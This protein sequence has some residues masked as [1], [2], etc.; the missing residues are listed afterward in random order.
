MKRTFSTFLACL[1]IWSGLATQVSAAM[2][3]TQD[4]LAIDARQERIEAIH[5]ELARDEV[6]QAMIELGVDPQE[7][8]LRVASMSDQ[9]LVQLEQQL[10]SLPAGGSFFGV[11][12]VVFVVLL[13]LEL[14]GVTNVFTKA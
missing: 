4:V 3:Q 14:V 1:L 10:D 6:Q 8:H 7:A 13:I 12:G 11:V 5:G 9:E 2:I